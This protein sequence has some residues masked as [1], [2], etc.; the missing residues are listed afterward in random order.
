LRL[1]T[2]APSRSDT[3]FAYSAFVRRRRGEGSTAVI[4][5]QFVAVAA[6]ADGPAAEVDPA[7][8]AATGPPPPADPALPDI[9]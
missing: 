8:L 4:A 3:V 6:L 9:G 7:P 5:L 2:F 1:D